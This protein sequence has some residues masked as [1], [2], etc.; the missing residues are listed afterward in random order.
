VQANGQNSYYWYDPDNRRIYY[1]NTSGA[2]TIYFYGADGTKLATYTYAIVTNTMTGGNPEIQ[3]T[4]QSTNVYF[5]GRLVTAEGKLVATDRLASVRS[6]GPGNLGYQAQFPY[7]VEYSTT[8]NDREKYA[9]YTRDS[10]SRLDYAVNRYYWSQWGRFLSPDPYADSA[11]LGDPGSWNRYAYTRND[12]ANRLDP[13]GLQDCQPCVILRPY[14]L[15]TPP[16]DDDSSGNGT[17]GWGG[18]SGDGCSEYNPFEKVSGTCIGEP[19]IRR[20]DRRLSNDCIAALRTAGQDPAAAN[21]ATAAE[22]TLQAAVKGTDISWEMLAAVGVRES[23]FQNVV[24]KDGAGVG[25]GVFQI[26]VSKASGVT[27][28]LAGSLAWAADYAAHLLNNDMAILQAKYP[29]LTPSQL[30][31]AAAASYNFGTPNISGNPNTIDVGTAGGNYG[32]NI[33]RLIKCF[34]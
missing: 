11:G 25:V 6:G 18:N 2:E 22:A 28:A 34:P 14:P 15:P 29:N 9:T 31:Q 30:L 13:A 21:R 27:A 16:V 7:G 17:G 3:L 12:P 4:Q 24:E 5:A 26:T 10:V 19:A 23:G 8:A 32:S 20:G 33:L 1:K